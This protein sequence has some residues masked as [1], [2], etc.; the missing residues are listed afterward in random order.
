MWTRSSATA[1][2]ARDADDVDF[3]VDSVH[4]ALTL[5]FDSTQTDGIDEPWN[6]RSRSLKVI[7]CCADR[8]AIYDF[9]LALNSN[10]KG[11]FTHITVISNPS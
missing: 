8:H 2:I 3:N 5:A 1:E 7:R 10:L 6:G 4:S 9:L 11:H